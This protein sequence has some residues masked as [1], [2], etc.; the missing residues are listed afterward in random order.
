M[1]FVA[2]SIA[3]W[4]FTFVLAR[5]K[6]MWNDELY[7]YY[8]ATLP[9]LRD[10]WAALKV[11]GEQTPPLFY[12]I[13]RASLALGGVNEMSMRLPQMIAFWV[14]SGC[15]F[16]LV[17]RRASALSAGCA[18]AFPLVTSAYYYG[19]EARPYALVLGFGAVALLCW[20]TIALGRGRLGA[21]IGLALSL[22]A[23]VSSHYYGVFLILPIAVGE[24]TRTARRR[25]V[26]AAVWVALGISTLPLAFELPLIKAG[27]AYA[28]TFWSPP[29]WLMVTDFYQDLLAPALL[30]ILMLLVASLAYALLAAETPRRDG[31]QRTVAP[32]E[33]LMA[34][35]GLLLLPLVGVVVAKT[36]TGA[37]VYRYVL[38]AVLGVAVLAGVGVAIAFRRSAGMRLVV[39]AVVVAWFVVLQTRELI[40]PT[41][42]SLPVSPASIERPTEWVAAVPDRALPL[43]VADPH[44]FVVLSHYG[45]PEIESRVVYLAD[46]RLALKQLGHNSVE[47]GMVDLVKPWFHLNV[48]PFDGFVARH[49]RFLVYGD[50]VRLSFLNWI[51]PE[52]RE[53]GVHIEVLDRAGDNMLLMASGESSGGE[54]SDGPRASRSLPVR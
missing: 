42:L 26:D 10:V 1:L 43:V 33:E 25:R 40:E 4:L 21:L 5:R 17:R 22:A 32:I 7:T 11:G 23:T 38:S 54:H 45:S 18:A 39:A 50:F 35:C 48:V 3:Y 47:R 2:L 46:P 12:A 27:Q 30:P 41:G 16:V 44:T 19:F 29:R 52:L 36:V 31:A 6:L 53:R 14:M 51:L 13:T 37:F 8:V 49:T 28:G 15:L 34:A 24:A 20:Q 9:S